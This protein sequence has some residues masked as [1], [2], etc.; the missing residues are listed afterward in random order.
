MLNLLVFLILHSKDNNLKKY[1]G[2]ALTK[3]EVGLSAKSPRQKRG[4]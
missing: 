3:S 1:F 4:R 2:R